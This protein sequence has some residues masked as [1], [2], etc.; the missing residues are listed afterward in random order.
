MYQLA[1]IEPVDYLIIGH[2]TRDLTANGPRLGGTVTYSA[3]MAQ[4]LGL[5]VGI[6]TSWGTELPLGPLQSIPIINNASE[7]STTFENISTPDG[8]VQTVHKIA[9]KLDYHLVPDLWRNTPIVHLGPLVQ[10][11]DP[12]IVRFFSSSLIGLTPQGWLRAWDSEGQVYLTEWPEAAFVLEHAGAAVV[13]LEDVDGDERRLEEMATYC[14]VLAVTEGANGVRIYWNGDI[15]RFP[16]PQADELDTTG[17]GDI[18]ATAFFVRLHTTRN[19]WEAARFANLLASISVSRM[20]LEAIP[21]P[22][23]IQTCMIEVF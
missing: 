15:R 21:T 10:E 16:A 1:P 2:I 14:Q 22:E 8:R 12:T 19:P 9:K 7:N 5:R 17:A 13:S 18:F 6:V 23:E 20:G 4:A 11:V 3:L